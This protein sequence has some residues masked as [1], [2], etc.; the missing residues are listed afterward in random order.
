MRLSECPMRSVLLWLTWSLCLSLAHVAARADAPASYAQGARSFAAHMAR[1]QGFEK[2][3]VIGLLRQARYRQG[4]ID[5]IRRPWEAKPWY[6]YRRIFLTE[7]RIEAGVAFWRENRALLER[8]RREYGVP[9]QIITA[10]IGVET[11]YGGN[12]GKHRVIDALTTLGFSYPKRAGF[13]RAELEEYLLL[14]REERLDTL[15]LKGSYA[16]AVGM[17]QFIPS[18]YRA[19]AVDFDDDGRRDLWGSRADVIGSVASYF[20]RHGWRPGEPVT[21]P[22]RLDASVPKGISVAEKKPVKPNTPVSKMESAGIFPSEPLPVGTRVNLIRLEAPDDEYWLG[23]TNFYVITRYNHSNLYAM[24]IF[25]L[26]QAIQELYQA[27][28]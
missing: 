6:R 24:A 14:T 22:A 23:L 17:P 8:A 12:L 1:T 16:G 5:A 15:N 25:Q 28:E 20:A 21:V 18:S 2:D 9:P 27:G 11:N 10:I 19:Y 4:I 7:T 26:S 13:F 3:A